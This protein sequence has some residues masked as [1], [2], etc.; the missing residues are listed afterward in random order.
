MK[1]AKTPVIGTLLRSVREYKRDS[2]LTP[3]FMIGEVFFE[4]LIPYFMATKLLGHLNAVN[5]G[6]TLNVWYLVKWGLILIVCAVL[7]MTSG[8]I[9]GICASKSANGFGKNLRKDLFYSVQNYSFANIDKFSGSS[10][11]TRLTTD[12][13]NV[14]TAYMMTLRSAVRAPIMMISSMCFAMAIYPK[15]GVVYA[16]ILPFLIVALLLIFTKATKTFNKIFKKYDA[17]NNSVQE[18]IKGM[19]V[20]KNYV[21][22]EYEKEKFD[23]SATDVQKSFTRAERIVALNGP[24]MNLAMYTSNLIVFF[25]AAKAGIYTGEIA[26]SD[27]SA[28]VSYSTQ[29]LM[30]FMF[31]SMIFVMI[32]IAMASAK[33]IVEVLDETST[34]LNPKDPIY[35]VS[36]GDIEFKNVSFKYSKTA[37][38]SVLKNVNLKISSGETVGILGATGSSK[39]TMVQLLSRLYDATE[40]EVLVGG[41]NV[42]EYDLTTLRDAVSIVL[43]KNLLFSGTIKENILWGDKNATDEEVV[44]VAKM[45]QAHDFITSFPNGYDTHIEQGGSNV[46]GGQKQ[47]LCIA[48][49]LL[50]KPKILI[51]DD[52]TSAVD[53]KTDAMIRNA[54]ENQIP[55]TTKI[56]IAQRVA[57]V[58]SADKIIVMENGEINAVGTHDELIQN[59]AIYQEVY[60]SQ[61]QGGDGDFDKMTDEGGQ[62]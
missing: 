25:I 6:A 58:E 32:T 5:L 61:N 57:S 55:N 20:V 22:E 18:N 7:S 24:V 3:V 12:V 17:L 36:S 48:R 47:R 54:V 56:I 13:T 41:K 45:A 8:S 10:L 60:N 53:M 62:V 26:V 52:S 34:I 46:S 27:L 37:E 51:L 49:A 31:L 1:H 39:S 16:C 43:Q 28:L 19:R 59:N 44:E 40:G 23:Y 11:L 42:K 4:C 2:I 33:R 30:S 21:R 29:V 15:I 14:Q 50:K 35:E 9:A 38:S